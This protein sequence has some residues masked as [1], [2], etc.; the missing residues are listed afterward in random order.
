MKI[1]WFNLTKELAKRHNCENLKWAQTGD[2]LHPQRKEF[3]W[4]LVD[5]MKLLRTLGEKKKKK[6]LV[7]GQKLECS[8]LG[9]E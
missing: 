9:M 8:N 4:Y 6:K 2:S 7:V 1:V 3:A 5:N